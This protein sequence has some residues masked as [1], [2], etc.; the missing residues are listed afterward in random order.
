MASL[1]MTAFKL[2]RLFRLFRLAEEKSFPLRI[3]DSFEVS[4]Y[5]K[6]ISERNGIDEKWKFKL[7]FV[8]CPSSCVGYASSK[9]S[10]RLTAHLL[11]VLFFNP[12]PASSK[13]N[14]RSSIGPIRITS[15]RRIIL[16]FIAERS[17]YWSFF[18]VS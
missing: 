17:N 9:M 12:K 15:H 8:T 16:N 11:F 14:L 10:I 3:Y 18:L 5:N 4:E 7:V 1:F 6:R 2:A 13:F